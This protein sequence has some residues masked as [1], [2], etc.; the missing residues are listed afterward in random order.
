[1]L[2]TAAMTQDDPRPKQPADGSLWLQVDP[3]NPLHGAVTEVEVVPERQRW[4]AAPAFSRGRYQA[5]PTL[6][7]VG[8]LK[9]ALILFRD[10]IRPRDEVAERLRDI[11]NLILAGHNDAAERQIDRLRTDYPGEDMKARVLG[12]VSL[13]LYDQGNEGKAQYIHEFALLC[14][15]AHPAMIEIFGDTVPDRAPPP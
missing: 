15:T 2:A 4:M 11:E 3:Q 12:L 14:G 8:W 13:N 5:K 10:A 7:R 9:A 1:M 6:H